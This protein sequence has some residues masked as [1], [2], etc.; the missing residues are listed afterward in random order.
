LAPP[1]IPEGAESLEVWR[2]LQ[3][4]WKKLGTIVRKGGR[5]GTITCTPPDLDCLL[6]RPKLLGYDPMDYL[7]GWSNAAVACWL[8]GKA[9]GAPSAY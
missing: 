8:K 5:N 3:T 6:N 1:P 9:P 7:S 2:V 4:P